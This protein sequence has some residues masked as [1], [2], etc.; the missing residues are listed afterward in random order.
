MPQVPFFEKT[1]SSGL[2]EACTGIRREVFGAAKGRCR[3]ILAMH[4]FVLCIEAVELVTFNR[5]K[6]RMVIHE[7]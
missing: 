7:K 5:M 4:G 3:D 1:A 6:D 2:F